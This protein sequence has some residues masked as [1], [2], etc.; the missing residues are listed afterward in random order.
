MRWSKSLDDNPNELFAVK[1]LF[2]AYLPSIF[3]FALHFERQINANEQFCIFRDFLLILTQTKSFGEG[4]EGLND[5]AP[6]QRNSSAKSSPVLIVYVY[7]HSSASKL[8]QKLKDLLFAAFL[9]PSYLMLVQNCVI[10]CVK[11]IRLSW[12]IYYAG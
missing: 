8:V 12:L 7:W 10:R 1:N 3:L 5:L 4:F 9:K 2:P 6:W 11:S